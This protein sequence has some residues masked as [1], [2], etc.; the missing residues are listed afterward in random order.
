MRR[1]YF[2]DGLAVSGCLA[3]KTKLKV[4]VNLDWKDCL[5][6]CTPPPPQP[7][8]TPGIV[9]TVAEFCAGLLVTIPDDEAEW[10]VGFF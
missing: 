2:L 7:S 3:Q 1:L 10:K 8:D 6:A 9:C 4:V 5:V